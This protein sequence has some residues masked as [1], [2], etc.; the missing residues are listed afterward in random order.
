MPGKKLKVILDTNIWISYLISKTF[1]KLDKHITK[2]N[3][4]LIFSEESLT[5]LLDVIS[6]PKFK[7]HF[8]HSDIVELFDLMDQYG[9]L[10][11]V[12]SKVYVCRDRKDD[13]WLELA[14]DSN[15]DYIVT[16]DEDL[17]VI[18]NFGKTKITT[19]KDFMQEIT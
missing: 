1:S 8:T 6:R 3:I 13:F 10:V 15:A 11:N 7:T 5:E 14:K 12:K 2:G 18:E 19:F 4:R 17:L 16:G 9:T